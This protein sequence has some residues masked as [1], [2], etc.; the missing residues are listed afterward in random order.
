M[1]AFTESV[2]HVAASGVHAHV[3]SPAWVPTVMGTSGIGE[4][5]PLPPKSVRCK[6]EQ[7]SHLLLE[8]MGGPR[9]EINAAWLPVLAPIGRTVLPRANQPRDATA[10]R[11]HKLVSDFHAPF[12]ASCRRWDGHPR[13]FTLRLPCQM[14]IARPRGCDNAWLKRLH[15]LGPK[16]GILLPAAP[17]LPAPRFDSRRTC[18]R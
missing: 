15:S 3:L 1:S 16:G 7:V 9:I 5:D 2:T 8:R 13:R 11:R 4:G 10:L 18:W 14:R 12:G 17:P 6:E